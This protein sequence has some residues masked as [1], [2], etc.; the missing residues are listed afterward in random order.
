MTTAQHAA[1]AAEACRR[2]FSGYPLA[3]TGQPGSPAAWSMVLMAPGAGKHRFFTLAVHGDGTC[4]L[5]S[6]SRRDGFSETIRPGAPLTGAARGILTEGIPVPRD[7]S[8]LGWVPAGQV[9]A[10]LAV[11]ADD[12]DGGSPLPAVPDPEIRVMPLAGAPAGQLPP[13]ADLLA[14]GSLWRHAAKGEITDLLPVT[15]RH[16]R[17]ALW[18]PAPARRSIRRGAGAI[19]ITSTL[20]GGGF[21]VPAGVYAAHGEDTAAPLPGQALEAASLASQ[22]G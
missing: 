14:D 16:P 18:V 11:Y 12:P 10:M 2:L 1:G 15:T 22:F 6:R 8:L 3:V 21:Q 20:D 19:H 4:S 13:P 17:Q 9:T 7:R 5:R